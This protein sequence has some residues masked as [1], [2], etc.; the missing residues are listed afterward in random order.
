[1]DNDSIISDLKPLNF[2]K[3]CLIFLSSMSIKTNFHKLL[4]WW[5]EYYPGK[6]LNQRHL[7]Q[8][9][10]VIRNGL[11]RNKLVL[12]NHFP[13]P[14]TNLL[15]KDKKHLALR[16]SL[17]WPKIFLSLSLTVLCNTILVFFIWL[18]NTY[19]ISF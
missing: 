17:G 13:W 11:I 16:N 2:F 1:M 7:L 8:S 14:N 4:T 12:R 3:G 19:C 10:L 9:N 6:F 15:H 5:Y 18:D